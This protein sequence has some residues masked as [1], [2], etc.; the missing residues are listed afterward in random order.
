MVDAISFNIMTHSLF[1]RVALLAAFLG[2]FAVLLT[3]QDSGALLNA[4]VRKGILSDQE[5]EDIRTELAE[6]AH[7]AVISSVSGGK[8]TNSIAISG[9]LQV[10]YAGLGTDAFGV[11][12]TSHFFLRRL[13]FGAK[14]GVG[15]GW[16]ANFI[17]D[18]AGENFDKAFI[19]YAGVMGDQP[20]LLDV[21]IRKVNFAMDETTS[22]GSLDSIER[23]G[24]TRYFVESNNG[25]RLGAGSYH[26]GIFFEGN[27]NARKQKTSGVYYSAAVTNPERSVGVDLAVGSGNRVTNTQAYWADIGYSGTAG[28]DGVAK[29]QFGLQ[30][31]QLPDQGG[32]RPTEGSDISV[33]GANGSLSYGNFELA[34]EYLTSDV[35]DGAGANMDA[36]P[37]GA[38]V[39]TSYRA[40]DAFQLVARYSYT[41][42]DNRGIKVSDGVRSAP[43]AFTGDNLTEYYLGINY[44]FVGNDMKLQFGYAHGTAERGGVEESADGLRSQMQINF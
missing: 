20:F 28:G 19:E 39:Q 1:R 27:P 21:G 41:D 16:T 43:A 5:A 30:T 23:S 40:T 22:S 35:D 3:A 7:A 12:D 17:Y 29:Y 32:Q 25:R 36:S 10:Q 34:G 15:E 33:W 2:G 11:P 6:E 18:F 8:S 31:G 44:Y 4:L 13:Y 38:W 24:A 42:S 26:V 9:R 14:A 37:W